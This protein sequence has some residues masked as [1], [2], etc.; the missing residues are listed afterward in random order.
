MR[1]KQ[2]KTLSPRPKLRPKKAKMHPL[3]TQK[4]PM[5]ILQQTAIMIMVNQ[6]RMR[7]PMQELE[8]VQMEMQMEKAHH[9]HE[10]PFEIR[11]QAKFF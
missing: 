5:P 3:P 7:N 2:L 4:M 6:R 9:L 8:E 10:R 1:I 11:Y